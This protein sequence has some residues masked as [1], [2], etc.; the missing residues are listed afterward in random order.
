MPTPSASIPRFSGAFLPRCTGRVPA[1]AL[2]ALVLGVIPVQAA[3]SPPAGTESSPADSGV[4][5]SHVV[6]LDSLGLE[7]LAETRFDGRPLVVF[8]DRRYRHPE[9][10]LG[11]V[12]RAT[13]DTL[14]AVLRQ[15]SLPAAFIEPGADGR[16]RRLLYP[17]DR[18]F[19]TL[20]GGPFA[21]PTNH[22]L[23][24]F[25]DAN[26]AYEL[27]QIDRPF[28]WSL[29]LVW[30]VA[31]D[32]WPGAHLRA[33]WLTPVHNDFAPSEDAPDLGRSR[34]G[35]T[36][37]QQYLWLGRIG[38][39]SGTAGLFGD[40]RWGGSLGL[41]R[42]F[43]RGALLLDAQA[44]LTGSFAWTDS[45]AAYS[46]P[47][48][49]DG[50]AGVVYRPEVLP[51]VAL[52]ARVARYLHEDQGVEGEIERVFGDVRLAFKGQRTSG[53]NSLGVRLTVPVPPMLRPTAWPVRLL[54]VPTF[55]LT[56]HTEATPVGVLPGNVAS[57]EEFLDPA[58][59]P[60]LS[61]ESYRYR[62]EAAGVRHRRPTPELDPV[63]YSGMTGFITTPSVEVLPE[64]QVEAGY[65]HIPKAAAWDS[66]NVYAN[67]AWYGAIGFL[68]RLEVG[69]RWTVIPGKRAF[70]EFVP[71]NHLVDAD[72]M[73]S[74][75]V[76]LFKTQ[77][78]RPGLS[79]GA[80]DVYGTRRFHSTYMVA[81]VQPSIF[82]L[83]PRL[84]AG[85]APRVLT[86][87]N[88]T[89]DG[90]FGALEVPVGKLVT[91]VVEY[92]S[93]RW[94]IGAGLHI[95]PYVHIRV[96]WFDLKY[97]ALGGGFSLAL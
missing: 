11:R 64:G 60:S 15:H 1:A 96:A 27:G 34:P 10:A 18:G 23:D 68:P 63:S 45:G 12:A 61:A 79:V 73:L 53:F 50:Y 28:Q 59:A 88:Y 9:Q 92:D 87:T 49:F 20:P 44:D 8:E 24:F 5:R 32:P 31:Y 82:R 46:N 76:E 90:G 77:G 41:A 52:R 16:P 4:T 13:G 42:P 56:Y 72:R 21:R 38:L 94:N 30:G 97:A 51:G 43:A 85:Y 37:L 71:D 19:P 80:E 91:S 6:V 83:L 36:N 62:E 29:D 95:G 65:S 78:W 33:S 3:E 66:R 70:E 47:S 48:I 22:S 67:E 58:W 35:P 40:N 81:G 86:A 84:T 69:L 26:Y 17:V 89:L 25:V 57:R 93:E 2:L 14:P 55:S 75:R 39:A 54:P 74:G 7:N